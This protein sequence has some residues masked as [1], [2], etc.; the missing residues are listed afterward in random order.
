MLI[1]WCLVQFLQSNI[2]YDDINDSHHCTTSSGGSW[3]R[4]PPVWF[5][6]GWIMF[7]WTIVEAPF[8]KYIWNLFA[9]PWGLVFFFQ[10][11][12]NPVTVGFVKFPPQPPAFCCQRLPGKHFWLRSAQTFCLSLTAFRHTKVGLDIV[13]E[14]HWKQSQIK[15][16]QSEDIRFGDLESTVISF[17]QELLGMQPNECCEKSH[18]SRENTVFFSRT[19]DCGVEDVWHLLS[20][21]E[22]HTLCALNVSHFISHQAGFGHICYFR[23]DQRS[24]NKILMMWKWANNLVISLGGFIPSQSPSLIGPGLFSGAVSFREG[25]IPSPFLERKP[26]LVF[27]RPV[28]LAKVELE[29]QDLGFKD[30]VEPPFSNGPKK[31]SLAVLKLRSSSSSSQ[32]LK[33]PLLEDPLIGSEGPNLCRWCSSFTSV[34]FVEILVY[35]VLPE[36]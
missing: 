14:V 31:E 7:C 3:K 19:S 22:W 2:K 12:V 21:K 34:G 11:I 13:I 6:C 15:G 36:L 28:G 1:C 18:S 30:G 35:P 8:W 9:K 24:G 5:E 16:I 20:P 26:P 25:Y 10:G 27:L 33:R 32:E 4:K 17:H 29:K 23:E